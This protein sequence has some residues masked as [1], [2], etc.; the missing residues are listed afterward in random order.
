MWQDFW[1]LLDMILLNIWTWKRLKKNE[2]TLN[3]E[4][5]SQAQLAKKSKFPM[6]LTNLVDQLKEVQ[7]PKVQLL[8]KICMVKVS[9][10]PKNDLTE[11]E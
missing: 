6:A 9:Q 5:D 11:I 1:K 8:D 10:N 7:S 4:E 3:I 2:V